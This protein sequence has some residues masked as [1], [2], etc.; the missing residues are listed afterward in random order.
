VIGPDGENIGVIK[1]EE[2]LRLATEKGLDLILIAAQ[3]NPPVA[4]I[5]DY[6]KYR[7]EKE[8]AE[9]KER[10]GQKGGSLKQIQISVR[11]QKNDLL[12]KLK[13]LEK[14]LEDDYQAEIR[15]RIRGREKAHPELAEQKLKEFLAMTKIEYKVVSPIK[16]GGN[17]FGTTIIKK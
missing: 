16:R 10:K 15:L 12:V 11:E 2:A 6:D 1:R 4:K 14:F 5:I 7:Y 3:A 13:R 8:K 17:G 9:R